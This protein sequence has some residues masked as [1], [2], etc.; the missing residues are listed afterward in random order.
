MFSVR[1]STTYHL[2]TSLINILAFKICG[3]L[4]FFFRLIIRFHSKRRKITSL[5]INNQVLEKKEKP[6]S[7]N[8]LPCFDTSSDSYFTQLWTSNIHIALGKDFTLPLIHVYRFKHYLLVLY[9]SKG[10]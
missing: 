3:K 6:L 2:L 10:T 5:E 8:A 1:D 4:D 9:H 7:T